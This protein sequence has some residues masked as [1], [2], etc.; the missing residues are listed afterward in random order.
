MGKWNRWWTYGVLGAASLMLAGGY[1]DLSSS[2]WASWVQ[3]VGSIV[4]IAAAA[5]IAGSQH[6]AQVELEKRL[7][8]ESA[9]RFNRVAFAL[10]FKLKNVVADVGRQA[11]ANTPLGHPMAA[12]SIKFLEESRAPLVGAPVWDMEDANVS[13]ALLRAGE[14]AAVLILAINDSNVKLAEL[15]KSIEDEID[16][17]L[18]VLSRRS[19]APDPTRYTPQQ[20]AK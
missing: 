5:L 16:I 19:T 11:R 15:C 18:E 2:E 13:I 20:G 14:H 4:A 7:M 8:V 6:R 10:V 1:Y 17:L 12:L 3:A 9:Q